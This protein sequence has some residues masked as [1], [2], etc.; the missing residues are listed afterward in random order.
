M[1]M[2]TRWLLATVALLLLAVMPVEGAQKRYI[3]TQY[4]TAM[5]PP[6]DYD[7]PYKGMLRITRIDSDRGN[8]VSGASRIECVGGFRSRH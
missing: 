7:V 6:P 2:T 4:Y 1:T 8:A 3:V 5:V